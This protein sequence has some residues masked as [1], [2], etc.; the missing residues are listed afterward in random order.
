MLDIK[1]IKENPEDVIERLARKGKD[2]REDIARLR[3]LLSHSRW[4]G[5]PALTRIA[6][7]EETLD[8]AS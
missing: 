6:S 7:L 5:H 8:G 3:R 1:Y 4:E 2:A